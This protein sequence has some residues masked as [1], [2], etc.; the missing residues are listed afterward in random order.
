[1]SS[2]ERTGWRDEGLSRRHRNWGFN[3]PCVDLDFLVV[4]FDQSEPVALVEYKHEQAQP[5][6]SSHPSYR[7]LMALGRRAK[8]PVFAVRYGGDFS[9]F[10]VTPL[11]REA[12]LAMPEPS[13]LTEVDYVRFLYKLRKRIPP[14]DVTNGLKV[15]I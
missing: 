4:E 13:R 14:V 6:L 9:W 8:V 11:T 7:A 2:D 1:M 3:C 10:S 5:L 15:A 12:K